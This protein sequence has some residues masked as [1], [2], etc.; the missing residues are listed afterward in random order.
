MSISL[1]PVTVRRVDSKVDG[2][3]GDA[4]VSSSQAIRVVFNLLP[5]GVEILEDLALA[6]KKF[7]IFCQM[8]RA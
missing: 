7:S 2:Q 1:E 5:N 4:L 3:V 8:T 6:V